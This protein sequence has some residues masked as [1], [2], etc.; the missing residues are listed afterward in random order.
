MVRQVNNRE[1]GAY[2][3]T[4]SSNYESAED[5]MSSYSSDFQDFPMHKPFPIP[6]PRKIN[7]LKCEQLETTVDKVSKSEKVNTPLM[8]KLSTQSIVTPPIENQNS[9]DIRWQC[10]AKLLEL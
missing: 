9:K 10:L 2:S 4:E 1:K 6:K 8:N 3:E 7:K 5:E